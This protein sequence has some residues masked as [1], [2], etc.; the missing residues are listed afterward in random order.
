MIELVREPYWCG[1]LA[2]V[3]WE[4]ELTKIAIKPKLTLWSI[5]YFCWP[6]M[7]AMKL[8]IAINI[9]YRKINVHE[10]EIKLILLKVVPIYEANLLTLF[11]PFPAF[12]LPFIV[13]SIHTMSTWKMRHH[14][15]YINLSYKY[16]EFKVSPFIYDTQDARLK[17][18]RRELGFT[19]LSTAKAISRRVRNPEPGRNSLLFTNSSKGYF[20]CR[21]PIRSPPQRRT[22]I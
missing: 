18:E 7:P 22:F 12:I 14:V 17:E 16:T 5:C 3:S 2:H 6:F 21:R 1:D 15:S 11:F 10:A 4:C 19:S 20:G 8:L 9:C 13:Y